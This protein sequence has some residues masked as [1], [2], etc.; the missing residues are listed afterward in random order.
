MTHSIKKLLALFLSLILS[1]SLFSCTS[2]KTE[3]NTNT[4]TNVTAS[5]TKASKNEIKETDTPNDFQG[6]A[7]YIHK[8]N[9]LPP[10]YI[11]KKEA[12]KLGWKPGDDLSKY[13]KGKS[14]GGDYFGNAEGKLPKKSGRT[15]HECDINYNGGKR[16]ADRILYSTDGL[17]YGTS[18]HYNTFKAYYGEKSSK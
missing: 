10:N 5:D 13:A 12:D 18:D 16:G 15:W 11:T 7:D 3:T 9:K 17:V 1:F 2:K 6:V 4:K 8:F 14:I